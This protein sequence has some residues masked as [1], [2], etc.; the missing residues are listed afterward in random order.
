MFSLF[1][2]FLG[3]YLGYRFRDRIQD[4]KRTIWD[5]QIPS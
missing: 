4:L 3:V 1:T 5:D 2:L